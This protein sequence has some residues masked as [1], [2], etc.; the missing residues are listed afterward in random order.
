MESKLTLIPREIKM[1]PKPLLLT[2]EDELPNL[3]SWTKKGTPKILLLDMTTRINTLTTKAKDPRELSLDGTVIGLI[4]ES[5]FRMD[6]SISHLLTTSLIA[7]TAVP[8]DPTRQHG[9]P[10]SWIVRSHNLCTHLK[11]AKRGTWETL[12][13]LRAISP[14]TKMNPPLSIRSK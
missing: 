14:W 13:H 7:H 3:G 11:T 4:K 1:V 6:K 8:K 9:T 12:K 10:S 2:L 5:P